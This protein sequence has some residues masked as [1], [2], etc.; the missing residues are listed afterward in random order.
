MLASVVLVSVSLAALAQELR[1]APAGGQ[2]AFAVASVKENTGSPDGPRVFAP[3][4]GG[5][6]SIVNQTVRQLIYSAY[7]TQDYRIIGGPDWL[8]TARFDVAARADA[9]VPLPQ[10]LLMLRRCSPTAS[11]W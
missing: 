4:A 7:Q 3:A 2:P 9:D 5:G 6:V 1:P 11:G 8:R 10:R